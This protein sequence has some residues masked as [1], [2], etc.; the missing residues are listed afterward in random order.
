ME[1]LNLIFAENLKRLRTQKGLTQGQLGDAI[2]YSNKA[3][4]K[5]ESGAG[6][7]GVEVLVRIADVLQTDMNGLIRHQNAA[8]YFGIDGGGTKTAF[9]LADSAGNILRTARY[10]G[11]NP[12]DIGM[13]QAQAILKEGIDDILRDVPRSAVSLFAGMAGGTTGNNRQI[14]GQFFRSLGF[15][16]VGNHNDAQ[17]AIAAGLR[18]NDGVLAILGTGSI[19]YAV[20]GETRHRIGG[21]GYLFGDHGSGY[22]IGNCGIQAALAAADGSGPDTMLR[23]LVDEKAGAT[24]PE[25]LAAFYKGGKSYIASFAPLVTEAFG[26]GDAVAAQI[27]HGSMALFSRQIVAAARMVK[28]SDPVVLT[29]GLIQKAEALLPILKEYLPE[30][31]ASRVTVCKEESYLGA[32]LLAGA[33]VFQEVQDA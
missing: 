16:S 7:P 33:P 25:N 27:L 18:G 30:N 21:Y 8:Y 1:Y 32:L 20:S 29:G 26:Q 12:V 28:A 23:R 10:P 4:S 19:V 14:L 3:I 5:W 2:N 13:Q 9:A 15:G 6:I 22:H 17:N 31:V 11:C 24:F